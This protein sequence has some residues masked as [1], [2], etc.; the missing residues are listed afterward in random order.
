MRYD[1]REVWLLEIAPRPI[2]GLCAK[3]L[4]FGGSMP[5]EEL[6]LRH[7]AGE[8]ISH[9]ERESKASGVMMVPIEREGVYE[10][11]LGI[12]DALGVAGI[13]EI[14]ITAKFGQALEPLPEGASYLGFIF[15]H[16]VS[17]VAVEQS[18]RDAH[19]RLRFQIATRLAVMR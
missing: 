17:P 7:A 11:V 18:L 3:S 16:G 13:E 14:E 8:D 4:Q 2:G 10:G 1:G 19:S 12:E 6:L 15:A 9:L 5:L